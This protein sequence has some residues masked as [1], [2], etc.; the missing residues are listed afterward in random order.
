MRVIFLFFLSMALY[1]DSLQ[2]NLK[3][4]SDIVAAQ[5]NINIVVDSKLLDEDNFS[6]FM[7]ST[8]DIIQIDTFR[9]MLSIKDLQLI[10]DKSF[11][12]IR[13]KP[14]PD[15]KYMFDRNSTASG[16]NL[17]FQKSF[18]LYAL[19]LDSLVFDDFKQFLDS[20]HDELI[21]SYLKNTNTL[22]LRCSPKTYESIKPLI[23]K[24]DDKLQ[25]FLI[26]ITILETDDNLLKQRG[27]DINL[28]AQKSD[29]STSYFLNLFTLGTQSNINLSSN[30]GL[31]ASL[32]FLDSIGVTK[33]LT[34]PYFAV[35]SG[36]DVK[37]SSADS[38][39]FLTSTA[40][41]QGASNS[42]NQSVTYRDVGLIVDLIPTLIND[43]IF[44]DLDF[45]NETI[46][47]ASTLTPK[48]SKIAIKTSFQ[49]KRNSVQVL[50]GLDYDKKM[51]TT[52]GIPLL[53]D[54]PYLG[55]LFKYDSVNHAKK[56]ISIIVQ[57]Q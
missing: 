37:F 27:A 52:N 39:P 18:K 32:K 3:S 4:F 5:N 20:Y 9:K 17:D 41:V 33:V 43:T 1:A 57:V 50:T 8:K 24:N 44:C 53:K 48:T 23:K 56:T 11:Y 21:Y 35:Q 6:F 19:K 16:A 30:V 38:I 46:V 14:V 42:T 31:T 7:Q 28:Y 51:T 12:F 40:S 34:S 22:F 36:K 10:K 47:D 49:L 26:G 15:L 29:S 2:F 25:Q 54:I 55:S 45:N 13:K